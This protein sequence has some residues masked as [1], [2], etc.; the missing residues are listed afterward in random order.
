MDFGIERDVCGGDAIDGKFDAVGFGEMEE[1]A[2]VVVLV[3]GRKK[4]IGFC[5]REFER[6]ESN[7][8]A[9]FTG[10]G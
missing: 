5:G 2:D 3:V 10:E 1:A 6:R 9:E 8:L 4:A 7:G